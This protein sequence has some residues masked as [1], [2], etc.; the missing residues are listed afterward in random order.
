[1]KC[2]KCK[3]TLSDGTLAANALAVKCCPNC[4]GTWIPA[5][6]YE[7]WQVQ[8]SQS[9]SGLKSL[10][11][12]NVNF[13]PS[14][15]DSKGGLCPECG[16]YLPR[17]KVNLRAAFYVERCANCYGFWCDHGEWQVLQ[18]LGLHTTIEQLF[19]SEW[20]AQVQQQQQAEKEREATIEKLGPEIA[21]R[22]FE[23]AEILEKHPNGDF[24]VAYLMR[25]FSQ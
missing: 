17:A 3:E 16:R 15:L 10:S 20:Q 14:E 24:A 18:Q 21:A 1:M 23:L 6:E 8:Q 11:S 19:S 2:P 22:V 4:K 5:A 7:A 12:T 25:R 13:V 9:R